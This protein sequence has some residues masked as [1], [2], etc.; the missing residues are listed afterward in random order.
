M[1]FDT[2]S[3]DAARTK[4]S[5]APPSLPSPPYQNRASMPEA[6]EEATTTTAAHISMVREARDR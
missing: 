6:M 1:A 5:H 3:E 4:F 2:A